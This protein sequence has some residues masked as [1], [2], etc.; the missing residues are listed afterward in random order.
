VTILLACDAVVEIS[1]VK[2]SR[3]LPI[4]E[5]IKGPLE[6]ALD[7]TD[8]LTRISVPRL[9]QGV[10]ISYFKFGCY[11]RPTISVACKVQL[12]GRVIQA[13]S[14]AVG[15]VGETPKCLIGLD[16][17]FRG[18]ETTEAFGLMA[19]AANSACEQVNPVA[20]F[21]GST[22]YKRQLIRVFLERAFRAACD[23]N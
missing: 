10:K 5:F 11:E 20:D 23:M 2:G 16:D 12:D 7:D 15:S 6:T 19:K 3:T 1:G 14:F 9:E 8:V 13:A 21:H 22:A 4:G 18:K 17:L